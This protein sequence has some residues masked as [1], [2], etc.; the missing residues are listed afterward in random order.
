M[1]EEGNRKR[2]EIVHFS[3]S[4]IEPP[5]EQLIKK[6]NEK[7]KGYISIKLLR[8]CLFKTFSRVSITSFEVL[9]VLKRLCFKIEFNIGEI[10]YQFFDNLYLYGFGLRLS[11]FLIED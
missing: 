9:N 5:F 3:D 4:A 11:G 1:E 7:V 8:E 6:E 2:K 10:F